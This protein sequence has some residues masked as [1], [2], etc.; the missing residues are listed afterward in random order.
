MRLKP[1][2]AKTLMNTMMMMMTMMKKNM[3]VRKKLP[4]H[5]LHLL[6]PRK[7]WLQL[8]S[9]RRPKCQCPVLPLLKFDL[10]LERLLHLRLR[11]QRWNRKA[12]WEIPDRVF[13]FAYHT[14]SLPYI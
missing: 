5:P 6:Q 11:L 14:A 2:I 10:P 9:L 13:S 4:F 7:L 1:T 12:R 8:Q 3:Q